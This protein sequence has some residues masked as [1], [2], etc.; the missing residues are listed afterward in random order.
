M[1]CGD[2]FLNT[3]DSYFLIDSGWRSLLDNGGNNN[4]RYLMSF[5]LISPVGKSESELKSILLVC[6][7]FG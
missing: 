7:L 2:T 1:E 4:T 5:P 6:F 3:L